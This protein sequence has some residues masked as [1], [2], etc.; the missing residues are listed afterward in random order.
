MGRHR[1]R[2]ISQ[3]GDG[4]LGERQRAGFPAKK[5]KRPT[6]RPFTVGLYMLRAY[7]LGLNIEDDSV[8]TN[9]LM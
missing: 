3:C 2:A 1:I 4:A 7:E 9:E 6:T 8:E 5:L